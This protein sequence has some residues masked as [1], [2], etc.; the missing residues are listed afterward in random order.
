[1]C[2]LNRII[3]L[4]LITATTQAN[5][6]LYKNPVTE[7]S[8]GQK[9]FGVSF[10]KMSRDLSSDAIT[11][12]VEGEQT[13][14]AADITFGITDGSAIELR[15]GL[16]DSNLD[17]PGTQSS[18]GF[19]LGAIFRSNIDIS[20]NDIKLG[21][22]ASLQTSSLSNDNSD[23]DITVIEFGAGVSKK[24]QDDFSLYGGGVLSMLDGTIS[25]RFGS[26]DFEGDDNIGVFAGI[27][28][29]LQNRA[30]IGLELNLI[31]QSGFAAYFEM[32]F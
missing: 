19:L 7:T 18:D 2:Y 15:L 4:V 16:D 1:M 20:N 3:L 14:I 6:V 21:G 25:D 22:F 5:A 26:V 11:G 28:K 10:V 32:P 30:T 23:T 24:L 29:K 12:T 8:K 13:L 9:S 17:V 31:H 27:E